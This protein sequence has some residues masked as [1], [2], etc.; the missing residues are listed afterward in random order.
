[1]KVPSAAELE[2]DSIG[3]CELDSPLRAGKVPFVDEARRVLLCTDLVEIAPFLRAG[4]P[5]P[6]FEPAGPRAK[7]HFDPSQLACGIV[8]CGGLCPGLNSVIRSI[9]RMLNFAFEVKCIYGFR[10][11]FAGLVAREGHEPMRLTPEVVDRI[12]EHGGTILGASRGPQDV[13]EM[14][15]TLVRLKVGALFTIGGD[16]THRGAWAIAEEIDRRGLRIAVVGVPKTIDND[17]A[18]TERSFGFSTAVEAARRVLEA[19]HEEARGA[20]NGIGLVKLMGRH[21]GFIA[22][23]AALANSDVNFCLVPEVP[24]ALDGERSFLTALERRLDAK[25]H[26]V[27]AVAEGVGQDL[28]QDPA[29]A[30]VGRLGEHPFE[31]HRGLHERADCPPLRRAG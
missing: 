20:W 5:P 18:W 24:L 10:Y 1:M 19:A 8:T 25:H 27:V 29:H 15:D 7:I 16:G 2:I 23:H 14:V 3:P 6:S 21:S 4:P 30:L 12:H 22:A 11:G 17:I 9:V 26:A 28:L 31:G 13:G